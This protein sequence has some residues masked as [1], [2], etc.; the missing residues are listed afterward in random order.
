MRKLKNRYSFLLISFVLTT[1]CNNEEVYT[2]KKYGQMRI[3][4]S[5]EKN[6]QP[7][8][9]F[10]YVK[11]ELPGYAQVEEKPAPSGSCFADIKIARHKATINLTHK[12]LSFQNGH[13]LDSLTRYLED[14]RDFLNKHLIKADDFS[15]TLIFNK[16]RKVYAQVFNLTGN[17]ASPLQFVVTDSL[18]NFLRGSLDFFAKPNY[19]PIRPVLQFI[20]EDVYHMIETLEW[21][22]TEK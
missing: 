20:R 15:D 7:A 1:A 11:M 19:D 9:Q 8:N 18:N 17:V 14:S 2:P 21:Q 22:N 13:S 10:C 12:K 3:E 16:E 6:Y 4:L 5:G